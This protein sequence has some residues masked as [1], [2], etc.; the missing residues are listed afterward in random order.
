MDT[1]MLDTQLLHATWNTC[2]KEWLEAQMEL[3]LP[4]ADLGYGQSK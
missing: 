2:K 4:S 1:W 3:L